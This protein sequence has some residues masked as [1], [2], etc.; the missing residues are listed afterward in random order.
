MPIDELTFR[1]ALPDEVGDVVALLADDELGRDR[2]SPSCLEKYCRAFESL[3]RD[4]NNRLIVGLWQGRLV[5][6]VQLTIIPSL[7]LGGAT[8]GQLEGVRVSAAM[9]GRGIGEAAINHAIEEARNRGCQLIQLT[10][11]KRRTDA[12]RFYRKLGFESS[13]IG[14]KRWIAN[15]AEP[16]NE[17]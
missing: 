9:R 6:C 7:T 8:R 10:T 5:S 17:N 2:E 15:T 3:V 1:D 4:P 16:V 13:H 14:M 12:E 11:N